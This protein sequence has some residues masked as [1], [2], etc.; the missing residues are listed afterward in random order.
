[1]CSKVYDTLSYPGTSITVKTKR[2]YAL[3]YCFENFTTF[4]PFANS[5]RITYKR[6]FLLKPKQNMSRVWK[7]WHFYHAILQPSMTDIIRHAAL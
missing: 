3:R 5:F 4:S 7:V 6:S 1:M 2:G